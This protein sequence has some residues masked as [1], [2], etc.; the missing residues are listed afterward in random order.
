MS[1]KEWEEYMEQYETENDTHINERKDDIPII[2]E[3]FE[4][5]DEKIYEN[6]KI[7]EILKKVKDKIELEL[8]KVLNEE[9]RVLLNRWTTCEDMIL[10]DRVETAFI[11]GY[12][13]AQSL[14]KESKKIMSR[15]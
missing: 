9:Q 8:C 11:Y 12:S 6:T 10:Y 15:N 4:K 7:S 13:L 5:F 14:E 3:L 2:M 1:E